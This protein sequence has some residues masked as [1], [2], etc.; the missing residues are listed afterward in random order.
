MEY[1]Q[2]RVVGEFDHSRELYIGP[3]SLIVEG[4]SASE[5]GSIISS[6]QTGF[7]VVTPFILEDRE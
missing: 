1:Q 7:C 4:D 6:G 5:G 2:V 3:R